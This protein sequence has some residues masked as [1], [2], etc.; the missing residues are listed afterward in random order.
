[1]TPRDGLSN[2]ATRWSRDVTVYDATG[3]PYRTIFQDNTT[4]TTAYDQL[5]RRIAATDQLGQTTNYEYDKY[6]NL[7]A[8]V[9]PE[10]VHFEASV[11]ITARPR[12]EYTYD[13]YGNQATTKDALGRITSFAYDELNRKVSHTLPMAQVETWRY[14]TLGRQD[15]HVD[16]NGKVEKLAYDSL[17]RLQTDTYHDTEAGPALATITYSYDNY[18]A[19]DGVRR[20]SVVNS[21]YGTTDNYSDRQG[22]LIKV[23]TPEGTVRYEYDPATGRK[24]RVYTADTPAAAKTDVNY[25]YDVAGRLWNVNATKVNNQ[26][27]ALTTTY[28]YN[29][30]DEPTSTV[31]P[32]ATTETRT[33]D[34]LNRLTSVITKRNS[35]NAILGS[36]TYT[37]DLTGRRVAVDELAGR[38]AEYTFDQDGRLTQELVK[39]SGTV[40]R[41]ITY[42]YDRVANRTQ[43]FDSGEQAPF[44]TASYTYDNN[45]RL[46]TE[47]RG[48]G[49]SA[50]FTYDN[51]GHVLTRSS[52]PL[53]PSAIYTWDIA[54]RLVREQ[55]TSGT[56]SDTD[57]TYNTEGIRVSQGTH[58]QTPTKYLIDKTEAYDQVLEEYAPGGT[59]AATYIRGMDLLFQ[60]RGGTKSYT[61]KD[62]LGSIRALTNT[63]TPVAVTDTFTYDAFGRDIGRTGTTIEPFQYAG[64]QLDANTK[65]YYLARY[66]D[67]AAG[68]FT[69]RDVYDGRL[70]ALSRRTITCMP[71]P[72]L[73]IMQIRAAGNSLSP[74]RSWSEPSAVAFWV[75][76][77]G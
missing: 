1:M 12:Y 30:V 70:A 50:I 14:D 58:G 68:R 9:L 77:V 28:S 42:K 61:I 16:F 76:S 29:L 31:L 44:N 35:D 48:Q 18:A 72:I 27:V 25:Q 52:N 75:Q 57:Y 67:T 26:A 74:E 15:R 5:G 59:L 4:V 22:Q 32:N 36:F 23:V 11:Q 51:A 73:L 62:G 20:D 40:S 41:T 37:L 49:G 55:V 71:E 53:T 21:R 17:G 56:T 69:S 24:T 2:R 7:T 46:L 65:Q 45:D 10:S 13:T 38:R 47:A 39:T 60:D 33:Y 6:G 54:G 66:Y 64:E 43:R 63:A 34:T 19:T 3:R 8:V